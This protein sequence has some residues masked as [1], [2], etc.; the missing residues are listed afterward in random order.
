MVLRRRVLDVP[1][2]QCRKE[3]RQIRFSIFEAGD[4]SFLLESP[5]IHAAKK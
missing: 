2:N 5:V 1:L 4:E 3:S